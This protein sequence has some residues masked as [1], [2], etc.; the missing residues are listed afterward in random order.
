MPT[1][2]AILG[3]RPLKIMQEPRREP[4]KDSYPG[5]KAMM[6]FVVVFARETNN[7]F[8]HEG[9]TEMIILHLSCFAGNCF[10]WGRQRWNLFPSGADVPQ[11]PKLL[12]SPFDVSRAKLGTTLAAAGIEIGR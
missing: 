8:I 7:I 5:G 6:L 11:K 3:L 4:S 2:V 1:I 10:L 12:P 9:S